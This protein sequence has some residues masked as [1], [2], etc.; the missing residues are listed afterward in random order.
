MQRPRV[1]QLAQELLHLIGSTFE[2]AFRRWPEHARSISDA[3]SHR[4]GQQLSLRESPVVIR[5][6]IIEGIEEHLWIETSTELTGSIHQLFHQ[7]SFRNLT[8][9]G[10]PELERATYRRFAE[11]CWDI[12][13]E[14]C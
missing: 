13:A 2:R 10:A 3:V 6:R 7:P 4:L 1:E 8:A 9:S 12:V 5:T 11:A 14:N